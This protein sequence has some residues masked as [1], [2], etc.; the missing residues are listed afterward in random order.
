M[1]FM[2]LASEFFFFLGTPQH[3]VRGATCEFLCPPGLFNRPRVYDSVSKCACACAPID[4][5]FYFVFLF[6]YVIF[7]VCARADR[8]RDREGDRERVSVSE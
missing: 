8:Q 4:F 3:Q 5:F 6:F 1:S 7:C 2:F